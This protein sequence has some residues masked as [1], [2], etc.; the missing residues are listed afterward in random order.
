MET[1]ELL[2][3]GLPVRLSLR[4]VQTR[5]YFQDF[6]LSPASGSSFPLS[7]WLVLPPVDEAALEQEQ[8]RLGPDPAFAEYSL[9]IEA[10]GNPVL[11]CNRFLFFCV[12]IGWRG[13]VLILTGKSGVGKTTQLRHWMNLY[14]DE[15][16]L[17]S[18]DKALIEL[19]EDALWVYPSPWTGKEGEHGFG[20]AP[21][22]GI[23]LLEQ[24]A[25]NTIRRLSVSEAVFPLFLQFL[26][27][28]LDRESVD[29]VCAYE[30]QLLR[31]VPVW[32]LVNRG[33]EASAKL[34]HEYLMKEGEGW[35]TASGTASS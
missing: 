28:P 30:E 6:Q 29:L 11:R 25:E 33:D 20:C 9:L 7:S 26:Y 24:G 5:R 4:C 12:A 3:A 2:A 18:G 14:G 35:P 34:C 10:F 27:R 19:R 21:L 17:I 16:S 1:I 13:K 15:I 22:G 31:T 32:K 23:V 8:K